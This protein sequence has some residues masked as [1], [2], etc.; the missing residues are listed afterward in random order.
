[1]LAA[2]V[3]TAACSPQGGEQAGGAVAAA[4]SPRKAENKLVLAAQQDPGTLDYVAN[5]QTALILWLPG[6]VVEPLLFKNQEGELEP[7]VAEDWTV[8]DDNLTYTFTIRDIDFSDGSPV[9]ADDVVFS[10]N[11]MRESPIVTY[12]APYASVDEISATGDR[13]VTVTLAQPSQAFIAGMSGMSALIQPEAAAGERETATIGT[14]PYTLDSYVTD[15][16]FNFSINPDYWG[17]APSLEEV[18]VKII[19]DGTAA[20]NALQAGEVDM[21]P[22]ITIDLWERIASQGFD[23]SYNLVTFP[24]VGEMNFIAFNTTQAPYDDTA[25]RQALAKTF[26]REAFIQAFNAPFGAEATCGYGLSDTSW[27]APEDEATCP[28]PTDADAVAPELEAAG[29]G[30][31]TF[32]LTSLSDVADLSLP[33]DVM[34]GQLEEAGVS[35]ER[36][37]IEL[38]RYSQTIFQ[39]RP[40]EFGI[41]VMSDPAPITQFACNDAEE[42]GW[43]TYCNPEFSQLIQDADA[44]PTV[45]EHDALM[46]EAND[47]LKEDAVIVP[48]LAK[49]AVGLHHPE[50]QGWEEPTVMVDIKFANLHW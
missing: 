24:Q 38:A 42:A 8:S 1:M 11:E 34:A 29:V 19:P 48:L 9:T 35:I 37:A 20:L 32:E 6:N 3:G 40:P 46:A 27:F 33:A 49:D 39:A 41:T 45:E 13:E 16:G 18:E 36:N 10:L 4:E 50:L 47:L 15:S 21:Y 14:G 31:E 44:A 25:V 28:Y 22:V 5:N 2:L 7:G 12:A 43:T 26:D 30:S 17:D 23:E